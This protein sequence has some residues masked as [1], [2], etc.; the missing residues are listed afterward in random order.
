MN[1]IVKISQ[2]KCPHN[3]S[4]LRKL[5][6]ILAL[7]RCFVRNEEELTFLINI[8]TKRYFATINYLV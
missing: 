8:K 4:I 2:E 3:V 6:K 5:V 7:R 1:G